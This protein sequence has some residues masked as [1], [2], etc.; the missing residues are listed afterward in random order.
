MNKELIVDKSNAYVTA[1]SGVFITPSNPSGLT[2][3]ER[4]V[5]AALL[6]IIDGDSINPRIE[7]K[8]WQK[9]KETVNLKTQSMSNMMRVL[10]EKK[11]VTFHNGVYSLHPIL[12]K[13]E[14]LLIKYKTL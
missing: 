9:F 13:N 8:L 4:E 2:V 10:K 11:A 7:K 1:I 12:R 3:R 5:V 14:G 6:E